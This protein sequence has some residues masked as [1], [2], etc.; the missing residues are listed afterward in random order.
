MKRGDVWTVAGGKDYAGKPRPVVIVQDDSFDATDS[1]TICALTTDRL[2]PI[3]S[4][5]RTAERP[6]R[7]SLGPSD[8][9]RQDHDRPEVRGRRAGRQA[10]RRGYPASQSGHAGV[11]RI[12]GLATAQPEGVR[13]GDPCS[14]S[15]RHELRESPH[16]HSIGRASSHRPKLAASSTTNSQANEES[17]L[18]PAPL[19]SSRLPGQARGEAIE[20]ERPRRWPWIAASRRRASRGRRLLPCLLDGQELRPVVVGQRGG[21][22]AV[23]AVFVCEIVDQ[24]CRRGPGNE[25]CVLKPSPRAT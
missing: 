20:D 22:G 24:A 8:D 23:L 21:D 10:R 16:L 7:T 4:A 18:E 11:S 13:I 14:R 3:I 2:S 6:K 25:S 1:I 9:G 17:Q 15:R 19:R 12:G 5:R